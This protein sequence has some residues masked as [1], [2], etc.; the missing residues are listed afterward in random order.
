MADVAL[1]EDA[2]LNPVAAGSPG[3]WRL[4][5]DPSTVPDALAALSQEASP[6]GEPDDYACPRCGSPRAVAL[7]PYLL[8]GWLGWMAVCGVLALRAWWPG[9]FVA[10]PLAAL[11]LHRLKAWPQWRCGNCSYRWNRD[12]EQVRRGEL[13]Q[14]DAQ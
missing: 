1:L 11:L 8:I 10:V 7:P 2:G 9:L 4:E 3:Q 12:T 5:I 13:R 6:L 14:G